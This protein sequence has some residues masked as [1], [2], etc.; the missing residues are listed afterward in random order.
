MLK[1]VQFR[2]CDANGDGMIE[3]NEYPLL[4]T[5]YWMTYIQR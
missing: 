2:K 5:F 3:Q 4:D 1:E